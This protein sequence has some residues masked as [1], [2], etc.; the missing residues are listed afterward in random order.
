MHIHSVTHTHASTD[1]ID[2][3]MGKEKKES[4]SY[5]NSNNVVRM[6]T[7]EMDSAKIKLFGRLDLVARESLGVCIFMCMSY[8]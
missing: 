5:A 6:H 7:K 4:S 3:H 1:R 8:M 2:V